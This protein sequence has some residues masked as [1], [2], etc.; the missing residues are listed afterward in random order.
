MAMITFYARTTTTKKKR[1]KMTTERKEERGG[2]GKFGG[3][4][5][6]STCSESPFTRV[7]LNFLL[8]APTVERLHLGCPFLSS[9]RCGRGTVG[10]IE[11]SERE[12]TNPFHWLPFRFGVTRLLFHHNGRRRGP[13]R[14]GAHHHPKLLRMNVK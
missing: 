3:K 6:T 2:G 12:Q 10:S 14:G 9:E 4:E 5:F 13:S 7:I 11:F 8:Q 1:E